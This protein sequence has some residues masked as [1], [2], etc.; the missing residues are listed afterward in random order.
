[1][2]HTSSR[3]WRTVEDGEIVRVIIL[4]VVF[5][6]LEIQE[7]SAQVH[8]GYS[9]DWRADVVGRHLYMLRLGDVALQ[10]VGRVCFNSLGERKLRVEPL[11]RSASEG[12]RWV[13]LV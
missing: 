1:M 4:S 6:D 5:R 12:E 3:S 13:W 7:R 11:T 8:L 2:I 10:C 9:T